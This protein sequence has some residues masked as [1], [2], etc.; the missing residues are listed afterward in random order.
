MRIL[1]MFLDGVGLGADDPTN[2]PFARATL[3]TLT[4]LL[5]GRRMLAQSAPIFGPQASLLSLDACLGVAGLPQSATG[6]AVLLTGENIP[7][8]LGYHYGP[9]PNPDV[10]HFLRS[11]GLFGALTRAGKRAALLNAYPPGYFAGIESGRRLYSAIPLAVSQS[12]LPLFTGLD[13]QAG[14]A[15][16]ADFTGAGWQERLH[17]PDTPQLSSSQAGQR[18]AEL[19]LNFDFSFFEYWLSDYAGHQQDMP[20]A[21]ALLEQ[22]DTVFGELC[23]NWDMN[24]DLIL[25]TSDHGNLEDLSTRRH[26]ANPVP[27]LLVGSPVARSAFAEVSNLT[28]VAGE[29]SQLLHLY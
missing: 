28:E 19:A 21:L 27:L 7:A 11:G 17:L 22:F 15:I 8:A 18:L 5:G 9:K 23:A 26:T 2:N 6:Q 1:F 16:S 4:S 13:L 24:H 3:P 12:G 14:Q 20:A 10:A 29:I 25:L